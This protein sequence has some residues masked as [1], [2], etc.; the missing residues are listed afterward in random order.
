MGEGWASD[1]R[2]M[3]A[4]Q[5]GG[6][7]DGGMGVGCT[8]FSTPIRRPL[9]AQ[10]TLIPC[11]YRTIPRPSHACVLSATGVAE[12]RERFSEWVPQ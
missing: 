3:G 8:H 12:L 2:G 10:P 11:P 1:G 7:R 9:Y 6:V 5:Y 4:V